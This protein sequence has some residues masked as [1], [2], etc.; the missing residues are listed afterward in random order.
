MTLTATEEELLRAK[1]SIA[2]GGLAAT[3]LG[4]GAALAAKDD[5]DKAE[6]AILGDAAKRL[7]VSAAEL[8]DALA[9]AEDAQLD[10]AVKDG[11]LTRE[12]ADELKKRREESGRVLGFPGG[13]P[14]FGHHELGGPGFGGPGPHFA[15]PGPLGDVAK[16]LGISERKLFSEL[17]DGKTLAEVAKAHGKSL[18]EVRA[19]V[20]ASAED[21]IAEAVKDGKLTQEQADEILEHLDERLQHLGEARPRRERHGFGFP[22]PPPRD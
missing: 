3:L 8:E 14:R 13:G 9:K 10:E 7:G 20:K 2:I 6:D 11:K 15:G 21:H 1:R 18:D 17:R 19:A 16:A 4:G 5:G 12:Q 22:P